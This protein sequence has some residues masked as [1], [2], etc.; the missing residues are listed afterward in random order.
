MW[1][2]MI[3]FLLYLKKISPR[4]EITVDSYS[5][6]ISSDDDPSDNRTITADSDSS[7]APTFEETPYEWEA[8]PKGITA[9]LHQIAAG[10]QST[11]EQYLTLASHMSKVSPY[12]LPQVIA[13]IPPPLWMFLYLL[14]KLYKLT[15]KLK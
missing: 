5:K 3:T 11:A 4:K 6:S 9:T 2:V 7:V 13:W 8:D 10:L 15:V 1:T 12:E 14:E